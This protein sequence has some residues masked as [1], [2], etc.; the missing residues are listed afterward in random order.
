MLNVLYKGMFKEL[1]EP[2]MM[3]KTNNSVWGVGEIYTVQ[4]G[5]ERW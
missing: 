4:V 5:F 3:M 1:L 2:D